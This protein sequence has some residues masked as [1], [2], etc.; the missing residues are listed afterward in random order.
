DP[1]AAPHHD[2]RAGGGA[3]S[4]ARGALDRHRLGYAE[5]VR[6]GDRRRALLAP[7]AQRLPDAGAVCH[8]GPSSGYT[9][10]VSRPA[11]LIRPLVFLAAFLA[12]EPLLH[13]HSLD[14]DDPVR[15]TAV[16][17][18]AVCATGAVSIPSVC[19]AIA[20]PTTVIETVAAFTPI[21]SAIV[22][23]LLLP[24]RAPPAQ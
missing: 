3:R 14:R 18:C 19:S 23:P 11:P 17:V 15:A 20:A 16:R 10:G 5:T 24:S 4:A 7:V 12:T 6:P 21:P 1:A 8:R 22:F 9:A 2:D 13:Q